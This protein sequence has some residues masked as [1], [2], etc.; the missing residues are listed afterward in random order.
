MMS[1][2]ELESP[3]NEQNIVETS[4][5]EKPVNTDH[6]LSTEITFSTESEK[7][8]NKKNIL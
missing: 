5:K 3:K 8:T 7:E 6:I 4:C 2:F 1:R